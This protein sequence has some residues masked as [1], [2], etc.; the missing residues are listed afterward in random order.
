LGRRLLL[1]L[2]ECLGRLPL[3]RLDRPVVGR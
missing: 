3:F 1:H 2:R